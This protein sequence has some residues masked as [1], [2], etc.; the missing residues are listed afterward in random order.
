MYLDKTIDH[1]DIIR[2]DNLNATLEAIIDNLDYTIDKITE[3]KIILLD[4]I[5]KVDMSERLSF[6]N[7]LIKIRPTMSNPKWVDDYIRQEAELKKLENRKHQV[8]EAIKSLKKKMEV[9]PK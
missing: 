8:E 9:M 1:E 7:K 3:L 5:Q 6:E 4:E 2:L